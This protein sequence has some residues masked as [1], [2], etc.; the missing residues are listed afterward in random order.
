VC[1]STPPNSKNGNY[2][3]YISQEHRCTPN[4]LGG[5]IIL[6][7]ELWK[8]VNLFKPKIVDEAYVQAQYLD[9]IGK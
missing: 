5:S 8:Q 7:S 6:C 3:G 2:V 1:K 9:N 4:F